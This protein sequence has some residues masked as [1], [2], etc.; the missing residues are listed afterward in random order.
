MQKI[1]TFKIDYRSS[2]IVE[3]AVKNAV[4]EALGEDEDV[5]EVGL[6]V[7]SATDPNNYPLSSFKIEQTI[8]DM[9]NNTSVSVGGFVNGNANIKKLTSRY[10]VVLFSNKFET[11]KDKQGNTIR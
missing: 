3:E 9:K 1:K 5:M 8:V 11:I 4:K 10:D 6:E 2:D 7:A